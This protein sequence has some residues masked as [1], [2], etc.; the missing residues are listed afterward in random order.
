[1]FKYIPLG[2]LLTTLAVRAHEEGK[3]IEE[4]SSS[5]ASIEISP[6]QRMMEEIAQLLP[7][8]Q[9]K[10]DKEEPL[11]C[12]QLA[13]FYYAT[14]PQ[15]YAAE[16]VLLYTIAAEAKHVDSCYILGK[17][18]YS[19]Q[20]GLKNT[21]PRLVEY[22]KI[23]AD[24]GHTEAPSYLA[25]AYLHGMGVNKDMNLT[26]KWLEK[27]VELDHVVGLCTYGL[28]LRLGD[29]GVNIDYPRAKKYFERAVAKKYAFAM[30]Q[31]GI[32]HQ[33]GEAGEV[34]IPEAVQLYY[35]AVATGG[36]EDK[37]D[38]AL[39]NLGVLYFEGKQIKQAIDKAERYLITS[40]DWGNM[41]A[42]LILGTCLI[43]GEILERKKYLGLTYLA[44]AAAQGDE[45]AK[46]LLSIEKNL[47]TV[48]AREG[49]KEAQRILGVCLMD[50]K[51]FEKD[52]EL[53]LQYVIM[54]AK[55]GD[56]QANFMWSQIKELPLPY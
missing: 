5:I 56:E 8:L 35:Q 32:M 43:N 47:L 2:L 3:A 21:D 34:N 15:D 4:L 6:Q 10:S 28:M 36:N 39:C 54:A 50:D 7:A 16:I 20:L 1:M 25:L 22:L 42:Q 33:L 44:K 55:Q 13:S 45:T 23:A 19:E 52:M 31:L 38:Q 12:F 18:F 11:A 41:D 46:S 29:E 37:Q 53:G 26:L 17:A 27:A 14:A 48:S 24:A 51:I 40:A 30:T 9:E 49:D